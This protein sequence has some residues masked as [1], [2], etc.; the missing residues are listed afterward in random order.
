MKKYTH[1]NSGNLANNMYL[2][3]LKNAKLILDTF[4]KKYGLE[5][6][7]RTFQ[8]DYGEI[9]IV[10][11]TYNNSYGWIIF[12]IDSTEY[13]YLEYEYLSIREDIINFIIQLNREKTIYQILKQT[14]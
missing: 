1:I 10:L 12:N 5:L 4:N 9:S 3:V 6:S 2:T 13:N 14:L 11:E 7:I 8:N